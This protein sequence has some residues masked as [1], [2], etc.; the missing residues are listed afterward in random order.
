MKL[1]SV[2]GLF[3]CLTAETLGGTTGLLEGR[4]TNKHTREALPGVNIRIVGTTLGASADAEGFFHVPNVRAGVY[5]VQVSAIGFRTVLLHEVAI[6]PDLRTRLDVEM[7]P[8][9]VELDVVEVRAERPLIQKDLPATSYSIGE[10]KLDRLPVTAFQDVIGLQPGTTVEGN[11]RGGK[12]NEVLYLVDGLPIQDV[13]SGGLGTSLP[14]SSIVGMT[15]HTGGFEAQYGNVMS[16]V[17][18]VVTKTGTDRHTVGVRVESDRVIPTSLNK[19]TDQAVEA[20]LTAGGP[21]IADQLH[22]FA[23]GMASMSNTR[24]WQDFRNFDVQ[25]VVREVGGIG[26][27]EYMLSP[28][29]RIALHGIYSM[30]RRRD[31]EFS[32]RFNLMGL[33]Q[34][35]RDSY[36]LSVTVSHTLSPPVFYTASLSR[37]FQRVTIGEPIDSTQP[38]QPYEYDFFLRYIVG[39]RRYWFA[40][41]RQTIYTLKS[42]LTAQIDRSHTFKL[43]AEMNFYSITS[44]L[45]KFEPQLTY[46]GKPIP[47]APLLNF[48]N[49][50]TYGPRTGSVYLQD[51]VELVRDGSNISFGIRW[52]FLD[53]TAAR[54][55]VEFI[56][57]RPDEYRQRVVGFAPA[58]FKH[59]FSPRLAFAAPVGL[60]WFFFMN[61]GH[62][63][64]YPLFEYLYSG[65][66]PVQIRSGTRSVLTGNPDLEPER[67]IA[68]EIGFKHGIGNT[69]VASA[70]YF[71]KSV[72]NQ[73]D[74][75]TLIPFDSKAAGDYGFASYVNNAQAEIEGV[76][77]V[78]SKERGERFTGSLSYSYMVTEGVSE[79]VN[80]TINLAQ[81]GFPIIARPYPLSWDQRHTIKG[82]VTFSTVWDI[83]VNGVVLFNSARPYTFYPTRDG[84]TPVDTSK[85]FIPNNRRME[86]NLFVNLKLM[87]HFE[88]DDAGATRLVIFADVRNILNMKNVR[89]ID[90]NGRIGGEL[91]D[92]G[93]YYD[94]RRVRIGLRVEL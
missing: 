31:Y 55:I 83:Q 14:K 8:S 43:G 73:I 19:Q 37:Y 23:A 6:L 81:W 41:T 87:R 28:S 85:A 35:E 52:D 47:N 58:R 93:A 61:F 33:P 82:E 25:P 13:V 78:I 77:F 26:K 63:F 46:F 7:E 4:V 71:R 36:R 56:P 30:Q 54:P 44:N 48:S 92:P 53:P 86:S 11:V 1:R 29:L 90:S 32:W 18:N 88:L 89:W 10:I 75:K 21:L 2:I 38:L 27:L 50:Y 69:L 79:N 60:N 84:Y 17:V 40:D 16:G 5:S 12:V 57:V 45:L 20:E 42:D 64:Q 66:N 3:L 70:T 51:K 49:S 67:T 68:W 15:I 91:G 74:S 65:I 72:R 24:W 76:E 59:Q 62:Y 9:A 94:P 80:Q 34:R 39:G 22:Y